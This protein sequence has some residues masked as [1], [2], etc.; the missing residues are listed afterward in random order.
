MSANIKANIASLTRTIANLNT[1]TIVQITLVIIALI[2]FVVFIWIFNKAGLKD[3]SCTNLDNIYSNPTNESYFNGNNIIKPS[4]L[5]LFDNSNSTLINYHVKSAYNCCCGDEYKN[6]FVNICAL[7]KC[8]SNG[9]RF[10]DFE[11]YSYNN[12]PIVAS[13]SANNN[14]IKETYNALLL[15]EVLTTII[16]NAFDETKTI[17]ANDPLIL[18]FRVMSENVIMLEKMG[19]LF[20]EHLDKS[21]NSNFSL[22]VYKDA[23]IKNI[24]MKYLFRK[25]I[26]ICNFNST[27]NIILNPKLVKLKK[28]IN[29]LDKGLYCNTYR[30]QDVKIKDGNA[31]FIE[32][33]KTKFTIVLPDLDNTKTNFNSTSSFL[34]GCQAICMKHQADPKSDAN[35]KFYNEYFEEVNRYSWRMK[36]MRIINAAP[37]AIETSTGVS[38]DF[39]STENTSDAVANAI[40]GN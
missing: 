19:D 33:T 36:D 16:T 29:L 13:S 40:L 14:N 39:S 9:C 18:N 35:L 11:I 28:Y 37:D 7:E 10:L 30:Y 15:S 6:N 12:V 2:I 21:I 20:E 1:Q 17:C 26:I 38:L 27:P 25:I 22:L 3:K 34:N 5:A 8:I 31:Q 32:E 24:K 4:A 23:S